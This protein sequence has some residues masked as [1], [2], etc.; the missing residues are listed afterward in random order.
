LVRIIE[1]IDISQVEEGK[2]WSAVVSRD[3]RTPEGDL[4]LAAGSPLYLGVTGSAG[5]LQLVVQSV[6]INGNSYLSRVPVSAGKS[7]TGLE[8]WGTASTSADI[9]LSG[10]RIFVPSQALIALKL[11]EALNLR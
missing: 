4:L 9:I 11:G 7:V 3:V 8:P 6:A 1:P 2:A 5:G 10:P